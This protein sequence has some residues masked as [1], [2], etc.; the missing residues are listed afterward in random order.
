MQMS[1][2]LSK[3]VVAIPI[4]VGG[5]ELETINTNYAETSGLFRALKIE[6][7]DNLMFSA[8]TGSAMLTATANYVSSLVEPLKIGSSNA[9]VEWRGRYLKPIQE[10]QAE[11]TRIEVIRALLGKLA[12]KLMEEFTQSIT[13]YQQCRAG[14]LSPTAAGV[15]LRNVLETLKGELRALAIRYEPRAQNLVRSNATGWAEMAKI[16]GRGGPVSLEV[17]RLADQELIFDELHG[18]AGLTAILKN[19]SA[20]SAAEWDAIY[21]K[22]IGLLYAVLGLID[23]RDGA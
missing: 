12:P 22:Y 2:A 13:E 11:P 23:F 18:G 8:T 14:T 5:L 19:D 10:L 21:S 7:P 17:S 20:P 9:L 15:A 3:A 6:Y 1:D 16:I 4:N